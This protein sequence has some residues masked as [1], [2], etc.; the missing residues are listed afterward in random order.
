LNLIV[1]IPATGVFIVPDGMSV[2]TGFVII[3]VL[4]FFINV[5]I[6]LLQLVLANPRIPIFVFT[7]VFLAIY[8]GTLTKFVAELNLGTVYLAIIAILAAGTFYCM[9]FL[10]KER[11]ILSSKG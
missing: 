2:L 7:L 10:T 8:F 5:L 6:S 3:P 11:V 9:R 1:I 4:V